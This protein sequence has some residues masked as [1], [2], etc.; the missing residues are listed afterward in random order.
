MKATGK[1]TCKMHY[2][3]ILSENLLV[4]KTVFNKRL[5]ENGP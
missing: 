5:K 4:L 3:K 1:L 2:K